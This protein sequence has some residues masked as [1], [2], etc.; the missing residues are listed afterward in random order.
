M[1]KVHSKRLFSSSWPRFL[2][3]EHGKAVDVMISESN[4]I[5]LN[6]AA[7]EFIF[8]HLDV[9][10]PLL[11]LY[12]NKPTIIIGKHQNPW[13]ECHVHKLE[14]DGVVLARRKSGGGAVYQDL[15]N[16]VFCFINPIN[17]EQDFKTFNNTLLI[18][19]LEQF[20]IKAEASGR[21]DLQVGDKKISGS[22]YKLKLGRNNGIGRRS[23][24]HGTMLLNLD[25]GC[26]GKYL[27]PNKKKLESKGVDSVVS[28]VMNLVE[29]NPL[30]N[31][32]NFSTALAE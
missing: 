17:A 9:V 8:E 30:I 19:S 23:L 26:L 16:S 4:D 20:N 25:L 6:L 18:G 7:E 13:K 3:Q 21:N 24:H 12:R 1:F 27:N 22:A 15:G 32:E 29:A 5:M 11:F 10:N 14:Q 2:T 28:R 31:H